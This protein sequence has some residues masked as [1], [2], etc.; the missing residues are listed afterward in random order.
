M[1]AKKLFT[2]GGASQTPVRARMTGGRGKIR[3]G[4]GNYGREE[5]FYIRRRLPNPRSTADDR[6]P[7][8]DSARIRKLRT[9]R[10]LLYPAAPPKPRSS[11]YDRRPRKD[12][13]RIRKLRTRRSLLYPAAPPKPRSSTYDRRP[14]KDSARI[15]KLRTRRSPIYPVV[16]AGNGRS[17]PQTRQ[18]LSIAPGWF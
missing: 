3:C 4:F 9:R 2:P 1:D 13:A 5:A 10:S 16:S 17:R 18:N 8:K 11:T 15:R 6:R 7:R 12:S 14:R